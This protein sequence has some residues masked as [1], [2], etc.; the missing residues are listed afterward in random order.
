MINLIISI[1]RRFLRIIRA[2]KLA[3]V[4][5]SVCNQVTLEGKEHQFSL[6]S[7]A[8]LLDG[9]KKTNIVLRHH[10]EM[11]GS[12]VAY[13]EGKIIMD[14]WSK[15]GENSSI[16]CTNK[17]YIGKDTAIATGVTIIDNNTHPTNARDRRYMRHTSHG[18]LERSNIWAASAEINIGEN[19]WVGS[20]VRI[21]KGVKIGDNAI[22]AA[23]SV[24][25]KDVPAN[26]IAAGNPARIVKE[27]YDINTKSI[28][29]L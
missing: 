9:A 26:S 10:A 14:E 6:K 8:C 3:F 25:T 4:K 13:G 17:V 19:V 2:F 5:S 29:P 18:S 23:C 15:I 27:N 11:F 12:L 1:Y 21:C 16:I 28:F 22:I 20:N 7:R 24:V